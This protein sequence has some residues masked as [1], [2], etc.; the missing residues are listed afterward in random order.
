MADPT[1]QASLDSILG[2]TKKALGLPDEYDV[3]DLDVIMHINSVFATLHQLGVG[4]L[5]AAFV[6]DSK[7]NK[8]SDFFG[9]E[10]NVNSVKSYMYLKV[11]LAFDPP[12][13]SF[14]IDAVKEQIKELEW[15]LTSVMEGVHNPWNT[16]GTELTPS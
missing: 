9:D 10:K 13:T 7:D 6:I 8:W 14:A 1:M 15:R 5:D 4:P 11:R 12:S 2:T 16:T 3:Y